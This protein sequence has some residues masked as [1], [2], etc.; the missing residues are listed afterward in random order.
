MQK[1]IFSKIILTLLAMA[2]GIALLCLPSSALA[3]QEMKRRYLELELEEVPDVKGYEV[4]LSRLKDGKPKPPAI[5]KLKTNIWAAQLVPGKYQMAVRSIDRRGVP[6]DWSQT[7]EILVKVPAPVIVA[8]QTGQKV[9]ASDESKER[10]KFQWN[11]VDGAEKYKIK[12]IDGQKQQIFEE[13][14][15]NTEAEFKLPVAQ[16]YNWTVTPVFEQD[17]EGDITAVQTFDLIGPKLESPSNTHMDEYNTQIVNWRRVEMAQAYNYTLE[18]KTKDGWKTVDQKKVAK[19]GIKYSQALP[20]GEYRI[21][22]RS[23]ANYRLPSDPMMQEFK[24]QN[25]SRSPAAL[26]Q[27]KSEASYQVRQKYFAMASYF[28]TI[29]NYSSNS[30]D[31]NASTAYQPIG[32]TGR[33]G[34]G[35]WFRDEGPLGIMGIV[36]LSG[37]KIDSKTYVYPSVDIL[38]VYRERAGALGQLRF[39]LGFRYRELPVTVGDSTNI[40]RFEQSKIGTI[41]PMASINLAHGFMRKIGF[42]FNASVYPSILGTSVPNGLGN[43]AALSYQVGVLGSLN[44]GE[45]L[46]GFLGYAYRVE[47]ASYSVNMS[48]FQAHVP[49]NTNLPGPNTVDI[50][51]HYLNLMMEYGF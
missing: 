47:S 46:V 22:V 5:F 32:G 12:V 34:Y 2:A 21:N 10:V 49:P 6:G 33:L 8:P 15:S 20:T 11:K 42:Q 9:L 36:D 19:N 48:Q 3:E 39:N 37:Y 35:M 24:T 38:G 13:V 30:Y 44:I 18:Q 27:I 26:E 43:V 23:T 51:G 14:V 25:F 41:G 45:S 1:I 17:L 4:R 31:F 28:I 16:N 40:S 29:L 7:Q 50:S